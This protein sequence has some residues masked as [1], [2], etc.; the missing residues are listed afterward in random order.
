M[1]DTLRAGRRWLVLG[2]IVL[3]V[4]TAC[5]SSTAPTGQSSGDN[6][7]L[8][9]GTLQPV[10]LE[11]GA[12][13][14]VVATT[15]I[16]GDIVDQVGGEAISLDT[17]MAPGVDPHTYVPTPA[18]TALIHDAH[19]VFA[20]GAGLEAD[21]DEMFTN[22]GGDAIQIHLSDDLA[23]RPATEIH[24][25]D[26][27]NANHAHEEVDPHVWFNVQNVIHWVERI[28]GSLS[29]LDPANRETYERNAAAYTRQLEELDAWVEEQTAT[30]PADNRRLV[31]NHPAFAYLAERYG[32]EQVGA[33]YPVSP[34]AEPSAQELAALEDVIREYGVP[35]VFTETTV[36]PKLAEQIALDTGAKL[37]SLYSGSLGGPDSEVES[38]LELIR[39]DVSAIVEALQ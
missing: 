10:S 6:D 7:P 12:S 39:F 3:L 24:G 2:L 9:A 15:N 1:T 37:V 11:P 27:E 14:R 16:V 8:S 4:A 25:D 23:L 26:E 20:N 30:I 35:A 21:L 32:L 36:N 22:A 33:I 5:G 31:T 19:V 29:T 34:S 28:E 13:L 18:D 17:L 38:Y